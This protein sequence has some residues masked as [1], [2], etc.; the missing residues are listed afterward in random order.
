MERSRTNL[1]P[2]WLGEDLAGFLATAMQF[3]VSIGGYVL[4]KKY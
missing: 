4:P 2:T 3:F 1:I